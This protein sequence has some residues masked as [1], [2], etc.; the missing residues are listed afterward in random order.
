MPLDADALRTILNKWDT[1]KYDGSQDVRP[2]L[3]EIEETCN[4]YDIPEIQTTEVAVERTEGEVNSVLTAMFKT[5]V[6]EAG[7]WPWADFKECVT[8]IQGEYNQPY[9]P[10]PWTPLTNCDRRLQAKYEG[11]VSEIRRS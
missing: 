11:S 4:I 7:V 8:Q 6:A 5:K 2:W 3:T 1:A 10:Q 9:Q